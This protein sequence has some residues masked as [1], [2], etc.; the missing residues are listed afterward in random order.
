MLATGPFA[1]DLWTGRAR[2]M[3]RIPLAG[4]TPLPLDVLRRAATS[5][6]VVQRSCESLRQL[7]LVMKPQDLL[8]S[9]KVDV[10]VD[11]QI[12]QI[13]VTST[14]RSEAKAA[15]DTVAAELIRFMRER[16]K[17]KKDSEVKVIDPA[18]VYPVDKKIPVRMALALG[19]FLGAAAC[20]VPGIVLV[21]T[22]QRGDQA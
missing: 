19:L 4:G 10:I 6:D 8:R 3:Q 17:N 15:T 1:K 13:E 20:L 22:R 7:G 9:L 2:V 12:L 21:S 11:T 14:D 5:E 18:Y 16:G